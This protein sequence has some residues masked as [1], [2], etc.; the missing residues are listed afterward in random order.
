MNGRITQAYKSNWELAKVARN[1]SINPPWK[2]G[3]DA[4]V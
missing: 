3:F 1:W 4:F 2:K